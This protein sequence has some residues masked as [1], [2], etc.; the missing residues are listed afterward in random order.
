MSS[1]R[2]QNDRPRR[3]VMFVISSPSGAGKTTLCRRLISEVPGVQ[4]SIS[5]TTRPPRPGE[6]DGA[7]YHFVS[8]EKFQDMIDRDEFLE[9][10]KVFKNFYG[11]P[12][13]EVESRLV[14][15]IDVVFDVDWQGARALKT[16]RPGDVC[17]VFILPPSLSQLKQR[18]EG[19]PGADPRAVQ[20]RLDGAG[21]DILRWGEYDFPIINDNLDTAFAELRSILMVERIRRT[22]AS[23]GTMV[24]QLLKDVGLATKT[25]SGSATS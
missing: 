19:R 20:S 15:G 2:P 8:Q 13:S 4:L 11:T 14:S 17:S 22:R 18:L 23:M 3:G 12:R 10:A 21:Q 6:R 5:A 1:E 25:Q 16:I 24:D 7:D 9:W